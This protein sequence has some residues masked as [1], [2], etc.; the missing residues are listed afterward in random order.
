MLCDQKVGKKGGK[1]SNHILSSSSN[2]KKNQGRTIHHPDTSLVYDGRVSS[3]K[4]GCEESFKR[5]KKK[6]KANKSNIRTEEKGKEVGCVI[7]SQEKKH[8]EELSYD[9][10]YEIRE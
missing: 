1:S 2:E 7:G 4:I 8:K 5:G 3:N 10:I 6:K 9:R